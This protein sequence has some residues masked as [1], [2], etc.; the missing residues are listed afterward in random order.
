VTA[1]K[2]ELEYCRTCDTAGGCDCDEVS[3]L[4]SRC[5]DPEDRSGFRPV[6]LSRLLRE[7]TPLRVD[8]AGVLWSYYQGVWR[9]D[10]PYVARTLPLVMGDH[11][12]KPKH[13]GTVTDRI[14]AEL[15]AEGLTVDPSIPDRDHVALPSGLFNFRTGERVD[16]DSDVMTFYRL[17]ADPEFDAP[18]PRLDEFL[19]LVLPA[20]DH[21]RFLDMLTSAILP[22]N[23]KNHVFLLVGEGGNGKSRALELLKALVP[24]AYRSA[25]PLRKLGS[26]FDAARMHGKVLNICGDITGRHLSDTET[27]K[28]VSGGDDVTVERKGVDA[29]EAPIWAKMVFSAN[30]IP[31]CSDTTAGFFRRWV[32]FEF[33]NQ[34]EWDEQREA[35]LHAEAPAIVGR[36]L[37]RAVENGYTIR[38]SEPGSRAFDQ[39]RLEAD[40]V[41]QWWDETELRAQAEG[42][43][44]L[45]RT[46]AF[47]DYVA[48]AEAAQRS[49][50]S[51]REF[52]K[53]LRQLFGVKEYNNAQNRRGWDMQKVQYCTYHCTYESESAVAS[54]QVDRQKQAGTA[55]TALTD[56]NLTYMSG[57]GPSRRQGPDPFD[58]APGPGPRAERG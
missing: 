2:S 5:V 30:Q 33:P 28:L 55:Q 16:H 56:P 57:L 6:R 23:P 43:G 14:L 19:G 41:A 31:S 3:E 48:W 38:D 32:V 53:R 9:Q 34:L 24:K 40:V 49:T 18:T 12:R 54:P 15:E 11:Y 45:D 25:V 8:A 27:F 26:R 51:N 42:S 22:G 21:E 47:A 1:A 29:T 13:L 46:E 7:R 58:R 52:F 4:V 17:S 50:M 36:L 44:F 35:A 39:L 10:K 20:E 37:R